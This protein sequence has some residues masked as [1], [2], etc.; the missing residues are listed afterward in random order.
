MQKFIAR[1]FVTLFSL[2]LF[3][4]ILNTKAYDITVDQQNTTIS[5]ASIVIYN[6]GH[7]QTFTPTYNVLTSLQVYLKDRRAGSNITLTVK[8]D[9]AGTTVLTAGQRMDDGTGWEVFN[10]VGDALGYVIVP[11]HQHS[12]WLETA[13]YSTSPV[14]QWVRSSNDTYAGGTRRQNSTV[15]SDD[16]FAFATFGYLMDDGEEDEG[17]VTPDPDDG[18]Q[19]TPDENGQDQGTADDQSTGA[20]EDAAA[21]QTAQIDPTISLVKVQIGDETHLAPIEGILSLDSDETLTISGTATMNSILQVTI[22]DELFET[23]VNEEGVWTLSPELDNLETGIELT[24]IASYKD[25]E[26]E[27]SLFQFTISSS[28]TGTS[29]SDKESNTLLTIVLIF[30]AVLFVLAILLAI[31]YVVFKKEIKALYKKYFTAKKNAKTAN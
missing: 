24:V 13:Y 28:D 20:E 19:P 31:C 12:I 1:L 8:D 5:Q 22:G 6:Y 18:S 25:S 16:D 9:T 30:L 10:F 17:D 15:Y 14:P 21:E 11:G 2:S 29:T 26:L 7:N 4:P 3:V 23:L 27:T